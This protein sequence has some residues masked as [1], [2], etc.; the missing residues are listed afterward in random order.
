MIS[1]TVSCFLISFS[2]G[3]LF[4]GT[5]AGIILGLM[6]SLIVWGI[7]KLLRKKKEGNL[8][9]ELPLALRAIATELSINVPFE[10][11]LTSLKHG[12]GDL[13]KD[14]EKI[15]RQIESGVSVREALL[16]WSMER[17]SPL[18]KRMVVQLISSYENQNDPESLKRLSRD[19]LSRQ[20]SLM[21]SYSRQLVMYSLVFIVVSA[22]FPALFQAFVIVGSSFM[23]WTVSPTEA[24]LIPAIGFPI[25]DLAI[26]A[27]AKI[28][29][30]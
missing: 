1:F 29:K 2:I 17:K 5:E 6:S 3:V 18:V 10:T 15:S 22:V 11:C 20:M 25:L 19:M 24:L 9:K 28:K 14:M 8:E 4:L 12:F 13:S 23:V 21:R 16:E 27:L 7:Q 30:P 26:L